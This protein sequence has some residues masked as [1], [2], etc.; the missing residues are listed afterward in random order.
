MPTI[1]EVNQILTVETPF[2]EA[3]VLFIMDYGIHRNTI[4]ICAT[5]SDGNIRHFD[6]NQITL[7]SNHTLG[8]NLRGE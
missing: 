5:F 4:W 8:F 3:Q 7:S 2:G 1:H 6:T